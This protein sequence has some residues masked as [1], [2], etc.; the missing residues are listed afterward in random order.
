MPELIAVAILAL[1]LGGLVGWLAA[2]RKADGLAAELATAKA[3]A[4]EVQPLRAARDAAEREL[5]DALQA[6]AEL[7][8]RAADL[9]VIRAARDAVEAERNAALRELA[10]PLE[11]AVRNTLAVGLLILVVGALVDN[12]DQLYGAYEVISGAKPLRLF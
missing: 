3:Q 10:R 5:S 2:R 12:W 7:R 8:G 1:V 11:A 4:A 6:L 9:D